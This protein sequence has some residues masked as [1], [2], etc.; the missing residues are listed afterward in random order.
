M[1]D[2]SSALAHLKPELLE[3]HRQHAISVGKNS[4][5]ADRL[6]NAQEQKFKPSGADANARFKPS[7]D[8]HHQLI[9]IWS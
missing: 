4:G 8:T 3:R 1:G 9:R 2:F 5:L 7:E 6:L